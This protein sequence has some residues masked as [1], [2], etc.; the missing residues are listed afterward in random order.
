[1]TDRADLWAGNSFPRQATLVES[2]AMDTWRLISDQPE[3]IAL[4]R[5]VVV[6]GVEQ[7]VT[8]PAQTFRVEILQSVVN[9]NERRD[10]MVAVSS[11]YVILAGRKGHPTLPDA[12]MLRADQ[13][14]LRGRMYEIIEIVDHKPF[15]LLAGCKV[16]P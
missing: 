14:Y 15:I 13:F 4:I 11:Q 8:L 9:A 6:N 10:A 7:D 16:T 12:D 3:D 2:R 5:H 1:M